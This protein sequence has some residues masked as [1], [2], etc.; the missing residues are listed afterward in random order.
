MGPFKQQF[1]STHIEAMTCAAK[2]HIAGREAD[3]IARSRCGE[4]V[5]CVRSWEV[6]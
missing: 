1:F 2:H 6:A 3:V 5:Y 4:T